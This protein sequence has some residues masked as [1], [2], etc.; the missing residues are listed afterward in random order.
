MDKFI[1]GNDEIRMYIKKLKDAKGVTTQDIADHTSIPK[2]TIDNYFSG[3]TK[4]PRLSCVIA[5]VKYLGGSLDEMVGIPPK[6]KT[7]IKTVNVPS[8]GSIKKEYITEMMD[9]VIAP[10][11]QEIETLR[12]GCEHERRDKKSLW[13]A[14]ITL[15]IVAVFLFAFNSLL[16]ADCL[17]SDWGVF[18]VR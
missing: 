9:R 3:V 1:P 12:R 4:E 7:E 13:R 14:I 2:S 11:D 5:V 10:Y 16:I 17:N 8:E 15:A 18:S 6:V